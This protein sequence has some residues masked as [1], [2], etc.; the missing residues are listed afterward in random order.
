MLD[1]EQAD[2][3]AGEH[4]TQRSAAT[5]REHIQAHGLTQQVRRR[6]GLQ[7][8]VRGRVTH[9]HGGA[10]EHEQDRQT[11]EPGI[12]RG[13]H[14]H[15]TVADG[16]ARAQPAPIDERTNAEQRD[17]THQTTNPKRGDRSREVGCTSVKHI[18]H[19]HWTERHDGCTQQARRQHGQ[20]GA[21]QPRLTDDLT[22]AR[23]ESR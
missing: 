10:R 21:A 20:Q 3:R 18:S 4:G 17:G 16:A 6:V 15:C 11:P 7:Q 19:E 8:S 23:E 2:G 13:Q 22:D 5:H 12:Q 9:R 1:A 14:H